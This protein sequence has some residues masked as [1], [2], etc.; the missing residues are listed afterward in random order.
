MNRELNSQRDLRRL[1]G[2]TA[3]A[4]PVLCVIIAGMQNSVSAYYHTR[5]G[6]IFVGVLAAAGA[7]LL[8][9][10]GYDNTDRWLSTVAGSC[11]IL[12]A[13]LPIGSPADPNARIGVLDL[14][15][16]LSWFLHTVAAVI[17]FLV[18][19]WIA[20]FQF[21]KGSSGTEHKQTRNRIYRGCGMVM[22]GGMIVVP[23]GYIWFAESIMLLAFGTAWLVKGETIFADQ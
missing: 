16:G 23:F 22:L 20:L 3:M 17:L 11:A 5:A 13:L 14:Q 2:V 9:Y 6:D 8:T 1:I 18:L 10:H 19:A 21:T 4:L 12:V 7:F 15:P